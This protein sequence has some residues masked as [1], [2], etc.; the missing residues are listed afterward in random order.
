M[1]TLKQRPLLLAGI[2]FAVILG[3]L[4]LWIVISDSGLDSTRYNP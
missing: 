4:L 1:S 3:A 2:L